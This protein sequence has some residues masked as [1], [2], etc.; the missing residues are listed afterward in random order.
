VSRIC[1]VVPTYNE[2]INLSTLIAKTESALIDLDFSLIIVDDSS[3]DNTAKIAERLNHVYGNVIVKSR[4]EKLGLGSAIVEGLKTSLEMKNVERIVTLDADLSHS[5]DDIPRLL[6]AASEAD[7]VQG[8]RYVINGRINNWGF[9]RRLTSR[10]ANL[11]CNL[12]LRTAVHDSTGNFRVYSRRCAE[13]IV[14]RTKGRGFE[15]VVEAVSVAKNTGFKVQ[16]VPITFT[17]RKNG[18]TKLRS[19]EI[20]GW[21]SFALKKLF[22][23]VQAAR[24]S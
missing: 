4:K 24:A 21:A 10:V 18:K 2:A 17:N 23:P 16:E 13:A 20:A 5:P 1:V 8:S 11:I 12:L 6:R 19:R 3:L 14:N 7:M 22:S 9:T 15:W